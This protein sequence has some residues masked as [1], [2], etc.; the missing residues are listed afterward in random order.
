MWEIMVL[1][2]VSSRQER[3]QVTVSVDDWKLTLLGSSQDLVTFRKGDTL[4]SGDQVLGHDITD[5]GSEV[6]VE[7][8]ISRSDD[9]N[10]LTANLTS[11]CKK[12]K[13]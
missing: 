13:Q 9:T 7:L 2:Q 4:L 11:F 1:L 10:E 6:F 5:K 3:N 12:R 8:D